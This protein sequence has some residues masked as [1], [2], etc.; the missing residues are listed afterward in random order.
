MQYLI[1]VDIPAAPRSLNQSRGLRVEWRVNSFKS[2]VCPR[3]QPAISGL[4]TRH[5]LWRRLSEYQKTSGW[6][7]H[8][9]LSRRKRVP[10][11]SVW[12]LRGVWKCSC[13]MSCKYNYFT[14]RD[15]NVSAQGIGIVVYAR[16]DIPQTFYLSLSSDPFWSSPQ[17]WI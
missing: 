1:N 8:C 6:K 16:A 12:D 3:L 17:Y 15:E 2:N 11:V 10:C 7:A 13:L 4:H 9:V 14:S 5:S